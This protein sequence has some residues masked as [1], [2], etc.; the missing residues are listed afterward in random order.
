MQSR[1][2]LEGRNDSQRAERGKKDGGRLQREREEKENKT[3]ERTWSLSLPSCVAPSDPSQSRSL[4]SSSKSF[5]LLFY[6]SW[7]LL[8]RELLRVVTVLDV[9]S[10]SS[11]SFTSR[12]SLK[13]LKMELKLIQEVSSCLSVPACK[14]HTNR[15]V[16][17]VHKIF[18]YCK[19][20]RQ[21]QHMVNS[22]SLLIQAALHPLY[23]LW[24]H[25]R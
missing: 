23:L 22:P 8:L 11:S 13:N 14:R 1:G 16:S 25:K 18:A 9:S 24:Q 10:A 21:R 20:C 17:R 12:T 19:S 5:L 15:S 7:C 4:S 3:A 6:K 2:G